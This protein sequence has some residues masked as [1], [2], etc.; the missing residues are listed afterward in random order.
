MAAPARR[1]A[2]ASSR[3]GAWCVVGVGD[4]SYGDTSEVS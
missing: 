1:R 3:R 2:A 4:T